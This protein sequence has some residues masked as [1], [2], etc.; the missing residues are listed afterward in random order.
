MKRREFLSA[1]FGASAIAQG[2]RR[3]PNFVI[4]FA[5]DMGYSDLAC[6]GN[7]VIRTPHLDKMAAQGVRMTSFY[8]AAAVCTPSRVG[9][10]TGRYP[11]RAGQP[12]NFGP[13]SKD[14]LRLTEV[15]LPQMLQPLGYRTMMIGK[16][17]LGHAAAEY[18]PTRRGFDSYFGLL[19]S[20]DMV[21]P[22]V[23]TERPLELYRDLRPV[24]KL[25]DQSRLTQRYTEE[26]VKFLRVNANHPFLLYLPYAMPHLPVS[27]GEGFRD[28]SRGG[29]YGDVIETIDWSV[30]QI[31]RELSWLDIDEHTMVIFC[32]DNGPW[33]E[34]PDRMLA[35]GV[36]P[37][38]TGTKGMLRGAKGTTW[39]GGIRVPGIVRWPGT[40]P[41]GQVSMDMVTTLDIVPT[42]AAAAGASL[43]SGRTY[44]GFDMLPHWRGKSASPR[45]DFF[46]FSGAKLDGV[47]EGAWKYRVNAAGK[48][49]LYHLDR[50][51]AEM[52]DVAGREPEVAGRLARRVEA[53]REDVKRN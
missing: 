41:A 38:H 6:Y 5:D 50:D 29:L 13:D 31:L 2:Q 46:Y 18:M 32:S 47:R 14:G 17:H 37:W 43:P 23:K 22:W 52:Y 27:A 49:E 39:E 7:P 3:R 44:D 11:V 8:A 28:K 25:D 51:P 15:L 9:L 12:S 30:G 34:L 20:N 53:F 45:K 35:K 10:L 36:E 33:H 24:E 26:A 16:W 1:A 21:P 48:G 40:I 42:V 4:L 19:Y